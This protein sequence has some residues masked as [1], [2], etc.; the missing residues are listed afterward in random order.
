MK[1]SKW[2]KS[3]IEM[4]L[5][6][7]K[8]GNVRMHAFAE[9]AKQTKRKPNSVRNYYYKFLA[10]NKA[11][12]SPFTTTE[13]NNILREIVLGTSRGESVRSICLRLA[14]GDKSKMLRH[15]NKYR[16]VLRMQPQRIEDVKLELDRQGYLVKSPIAAP[17]NVIT[18]PARQT[19]K[20]TDSDINNLFLGLM[21]LV[22]KQAVDSQ[23]DGLRTQVEELKAEIQRLKVSAKVRVK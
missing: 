23:V 14:N 4:L 11:K 19:Q 2:T 6:K 18:M 3:Q 22:K 12:V 17:R 20:I 7:T 15:Q 21:R 16:A 8:A 5:E 13:V 10:D 9:V 1:K